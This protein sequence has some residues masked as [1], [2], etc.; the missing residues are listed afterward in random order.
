MKKKSKLTNTL[1]NLVTF[2]RSREQT[3]LEIL[4]G[5]LDQVFRYAGIKR[6][7]VAWYE[8][9]LNGIY[10]AKNNVALG[11]WYKNRVVQ[12][13]TKRGRLHLN[14]I[15]IQ[16]KVDYGYRDLTLS[17]KEQEL[18]LARQEKQNRVYKI[19]FR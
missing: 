14:K 2:N 9:L 13:G 12:L 3:K 10:T 11:T 4:Y 6:A 15:P 5:N 8:V 16:R 1:W 19:E 17:V 18:K 7:D